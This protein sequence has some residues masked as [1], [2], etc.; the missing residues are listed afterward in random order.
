M[1]LPHSL[2][3]IILLLRIAL[4]LQFIYAVPFAQLHTPTQWA[5]LIIG[6]FLVVGLLTRLSSIVGIV[7]ILLSYLPTLNY[8][9]LNVPQYVG[10]DAILVICL[11]VIIFSNAG[12]YVG[13]D[14]FIHIHPPKKKPKE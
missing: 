2:R 7:L 8:S 1:K 14:T 12:T 13:L 4:G 6:G 11:L 3:V 9:V 10:T 5:F